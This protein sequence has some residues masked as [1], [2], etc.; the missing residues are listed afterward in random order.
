MSSPGLP[1]ARISHPARRRVGPGWRTRRSAVLAN[2]VDQLPLP[3]PRPAR[4]PLSLGDL[5]ELLPVAVLE[6]VAGLAT[7]LTA[8]SGLFLQSPPGAL[9]KQRDGALLARCRLGLL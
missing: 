5:V 8:V 4:D 7:A 9:G 2:R 6:G 3:H 1:P